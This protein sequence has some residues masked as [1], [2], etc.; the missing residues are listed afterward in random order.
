M[1]LMENCQIKTSPKQ[2]CAKFCFLIGRRSDQMTFEELE[3][4]VSE[5]NR[6]STNEDKRLFIA[7]EILATEKSYLDSLDK[8]VKVCLNVC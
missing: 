2:E 5:E 8:I 7:K 6:D 4:A 3:T 1:Y